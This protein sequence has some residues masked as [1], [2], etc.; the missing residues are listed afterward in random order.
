MIDPDGR[1]GEATIDKENK[2]ITVSSHIY[3]YG[4]QATEDIATKSATEIQDMWN[5]AG[6]T[7]EIDGVEYS[8]QFNI[9]SEVVSEDK[10][11]ELAGENTSTLNNFV[12][13][14]DSNIASRS[15][16]DDIGGNSGHWITSDK[17]G[18]S[19]TAAHEMGHG[20]NLEHSE[21]DQRGKG[22]PDIMAA[23]GTLV[24]SEYQ[25]NPK[26][27][28]GA[29]GGTVNP[30]HRKVLQRNITGAFK[31][32]TFDKNGKANIGRATNTIF[33]KDG[34]RK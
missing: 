6:G 8:V 14:E 34:T 21:G 16:M 19:T 25:W 17:L 33:K 1:S 20:Y 27:A 7:V 9:T 22:T 5:A 3:F 18:E 29:Y 23:R 12:R 4:S 11:T 26:A 10:A 24:D 28:A 30:K 2:T 31:G 15:F 32:V 13:V